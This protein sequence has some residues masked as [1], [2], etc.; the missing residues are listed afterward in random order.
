MFEQ[1]TAFLSAKEK[2]NLPMLAEALDEDGF[3]IV[4]FGGTGD[5]IK[6]LHINVISP[7]EF[8]G[9]PE[10]DK[11]LPKYNDRTQREIVGVFAAPCLEY[12]P[13]DLAQR[14]IPALDFAYINLMPGEVKTDGGTNYEG[15]KTDKGGGLIIRA[16]LEGKR[17]V[18]VVPSQIPGFVESLADNHRAVGQAMSLGFQALRY[19]Q[20]HDI[21]V[22]EQF[23]DLARSQG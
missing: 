10:L 14:G 2:T 21:P 7:A 1:K 18:L 22:L 3:N 5:E 17:E 12:A 13:E 20:G 6:K 11:I 16:A 19:L 9:M 8:L 23:L 15:T 4:S